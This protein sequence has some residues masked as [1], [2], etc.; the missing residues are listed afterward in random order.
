M[1]TVL[2]LIHH[3]I[4]YIFAR[5]EELEFGELSN[6]VPLQCVSAKSAW[7]P[8]AATQM[9][10]QLD[11][12]LRDKPA[13]AKASGFLAG[14]IAPASEAD[15]ESAVSSFFSLLPAQKPGAFDHWLRLSD[16]DLLERLCEFEAIT[17]TMSADAAAINK[18]PKLDYQFDHCSAHTSNVVPVAAVAVNSAN[19]SAHDNLKSRFKS[20]KKQFG[21]EV[22]SPQVHRS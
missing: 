10:Y 16:R 8:L 20:A 17:A 12:L 4:V 15:I 5:I 7:D 9:E 3:S 19:N 22:W 11:A 1:Q 21:E 18:K 2:F 13:L 6:R 14:D